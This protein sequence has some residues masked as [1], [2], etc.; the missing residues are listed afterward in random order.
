MT[1]ILTPA[2]AAKALAVSPATLK[3]WTAERRIAALEL[4]PARGTRPLLRYRQED[5][6]AFLL[7]RRRPVRPVGVMRRTRKPAGGYSA[8]VARTRPLA[9]VERSSR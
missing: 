1:V 5:V 9:L 2:E 7:A 3:R 8:L 6:E 4:P